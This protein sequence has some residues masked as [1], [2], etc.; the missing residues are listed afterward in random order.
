MWDYYVILPVHENILEKVL[1]LQKLTP[2]YM[3]NAPVH[4]PGQLR[5]LSAGIAI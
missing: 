5:T 2:L 1:L 4:G 3:A